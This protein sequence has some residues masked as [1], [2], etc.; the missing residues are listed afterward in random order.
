MDQRGKVPLQEVE[1]IVRENEGAM[2]EQVAE[3]AHLNQESVLHIRRIEDSESG[4]TLNFY[5]ILHLS[6][7]WQ[8]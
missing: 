1:E 5:D 8:F 4:L 6:G 3:L 7:F 2:L